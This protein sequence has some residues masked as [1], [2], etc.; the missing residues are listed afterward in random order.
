MNRRARMH[1]ARILEM[2][3]KGQETKLRGV[4]LADE[5]LAALPKE[6]EAKVRLGASMRLYVYP[7]TQVS[8][9]EVQVDGHSYVHELERDV[10]LEVIWGAVGALEL[11]Y[12][13]FDRGNRLWERPPRPGVWR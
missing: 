6:V 9:I 2:Q 13:G 5:I 3:L 10:T 1:A 11:T 12:R 8:T 4:A 7:S